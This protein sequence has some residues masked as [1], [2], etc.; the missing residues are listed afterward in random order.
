[1]IIQHLTGAQ[2]HAV[3]SELGPA[4]I[5]FTYFLE[6][7]VNL[8]ESSFSSHLPET[9]VSYICSPQSTAALAELQVYHDKFLESRV[10]YVQGVGSILC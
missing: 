9:K 4:L 2:L 8:M 1:M 7:S 3:K 10:K 5:L 6:K